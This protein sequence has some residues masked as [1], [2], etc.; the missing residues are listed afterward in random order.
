M[1]LDKRR[2]APMTGR[3]SSDTITGGATRTTH[4]AYSKRKVKV[5]RRG[6]DGN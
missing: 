2:N 1:L 6:R 4:I 3:Q 5:I